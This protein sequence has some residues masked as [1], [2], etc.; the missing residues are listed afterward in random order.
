MGAQP[1]RLGIAP[2]RPQPGT[3]GAADPLDLRQRGRQPLRV[4][5]QFRREA[6]S[7]ELTH[8]RQAELCEQGQLGRGGQQKQSRPIDRHRAGQQCGQAEHNSDLSDHSQQAREATDGIRQPHDAQILIGDVHDLVREHTRQL[9]WAQAAQQAIGEGDRCLL[10]RSGGEGVDDGTG[11]VVRHRR[12][13]QTGTGGQFAQQGPNLGRFLRAQGPYAVQ[14][15]AQRRRGYRFQQQRTCNGKQR[16]PQAA[17]PKR[18]YPCCGCDPDQGQDQQPG[19]QAV[20]PAVLQQRRARI[21]GMM[22]GHAQRSRR[23]GRRA[24]AAASRSHPEPAWRLPARL[25][26]RGSPRGQGSR[27]CAPARSDR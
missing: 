16:E 15:Q 9:A 2:S 20:E 19:L 22:T 5:G 17:F 25:S 21:T 24:C 10:L 11:H 4:A 26:W 12:G 23:H 13:G 1:G 27:T 18:Q 7:V 14:A 3:P 6:V 8:A